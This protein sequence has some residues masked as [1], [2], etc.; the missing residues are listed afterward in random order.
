VGERIRAAIRERGPITFA[1]FMREALYGPGGFYQGTPVGERGHFVTSP[2][3]HPVFSRLVGAAIEELWEAMGR[4]APLRVVEAGAGDGTMGREIVDGFARGGI[5][6]D[7]VAVE[8][9]RGGRGAI[10]AAGLRAVERIED[11]SP[12]DPGV[13]VA[14]ELLDNLPFRRVRANGGELVEV[15]VGLDG[16]RL[17]EV[18]VEGDPELRALAPPLRDGEEAAVPTG[19]LAF[20]ERLGSWMRSGYALLIDYAAMDAAGSEPHAYR[21]HRLV[22]DLL[23]RPGSADLTAGVDLEA[24]AGRARQRGLVPVGPVTQRAALGALGLDEW[25]RSERARQGD[26]LNEGR[27]AEAA[28]AWD[29]R[30]RAGL[31]VDRA[32]L[33]RLQWILLATVGRSPPRWIERAIAVDRLG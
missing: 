32:A 14:N 26:L 15:L 22:R 24:V 17:A 29:G 4:P 31:L 12:L 20:I 6:L 13:L 5:P 8:A 3:A 23:D 27:G 16:D 10:E 33:G 11:V 28:R 19:A 25:L 18:E 30:S 2:H 7:Y 9:G 21:D 1:E